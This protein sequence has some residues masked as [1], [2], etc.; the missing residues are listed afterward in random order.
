MY[1]IFHSYTEQ[2]LLNSQ[3]QQEEYRELQSCEKNEQNIIIYFDS[4][5]LIV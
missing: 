2:E 3:L 5:N 1:D 4:W